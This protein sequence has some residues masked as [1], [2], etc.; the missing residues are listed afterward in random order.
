VSP[1][2]KSVP[3]TINGMPGAEINYECGIHLAAMPGK[4]KIV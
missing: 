4:I 3:V 2:P 1:V